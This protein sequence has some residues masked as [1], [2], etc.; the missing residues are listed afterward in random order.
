VPAAVHKHALQRAVEMAG[1]T[2]A[3]ARQLQVPPTAVRFWLAN[4]SPLPDDI[5]LKVVDLLL[6]RDAGGKAPD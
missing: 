2:D 6:A 3:L 5:F 1:G 4:S